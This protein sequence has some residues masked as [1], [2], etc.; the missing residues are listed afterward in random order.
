MTVRLAC[1]G[2]A[3]KKRVGGAYTWSFRL[4][5][6]CEPSLRDQSILNWLFRD[7]DWH[8]LPLGYN[9]HPR[10]WPA[11]AR[12]TLTARVAIVH[13]AGDGKPWEEPP[14]PLRDG[15][16]HPNALPDVLVS[17]WREACPDTRRLLK[18]GSK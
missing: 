13:Y 2:E 7:G 11:V 12:E 10:L 4:R 9:L 15:T 8:R 18:M 17:R 5:K 1:V 3:D 16:P 14:K 6:V